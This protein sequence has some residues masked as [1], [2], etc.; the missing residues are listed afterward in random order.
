MF[1]SGLRVIGGRLARLRRGAIGPKANADYSNYSMQQHAED[2]LAAL[3]AL[4][5]KFCHHRYAFDR[6]PS[7]PR[8]CS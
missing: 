4:D 5:I 1:P 3:D 8:G 2:M 6:R 7:S